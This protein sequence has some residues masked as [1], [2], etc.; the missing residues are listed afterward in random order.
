MSKTSTGI[1]EF[2]AVILNAYEADGRISG[3]CYC[4]RE[5]RFLDG[6]LITTSPIV[7]RIAPTIIRTRNSTYKV[8]WG[9]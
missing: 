9:A 8:M 7:E 6:E 5:R 2:T 4:D 3:R 1:G